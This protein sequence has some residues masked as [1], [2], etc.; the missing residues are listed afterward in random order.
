MTASQTSARRRKPSGSASA[1]Q[2]CLRSKPPAHND[3][4]NAR[5][6]MTGR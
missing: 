2:N 5:P 3:H 1:A 6:A 4:G